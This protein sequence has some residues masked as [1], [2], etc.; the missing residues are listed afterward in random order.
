MGSAVQAT[1]SISCIHLNLPML[2]NFQLSALGTIVRRNFKLYNRHWSGPIYGLVVTAGV[3]FP[4]FVVISELRTIVPRKVCFE[5]KMRG[6]AGFYWHTTS[7][8]VLGLGPGRGGEKLF[9][10]IHLSL[11]SEREVE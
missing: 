6:C 4:L 11:N 1:I 2:E 3:C 9:A 7:S 5:Q 8:G 10:R